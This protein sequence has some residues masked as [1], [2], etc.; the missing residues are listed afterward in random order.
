MPLAEYRSPVAK[1]LMRSAAYDILRDAII[2]GELEPG[3]AIKD[4]ELA[5]RM[6]L[7][8]TPV[9]EAVAKLADAGLI[10]LKPGVYTRVAPLDRRSVRATLDILRVLDD[11][12]VRTAVPAL[13][14]GDL[15]AMREANDRFAEAVAR[16]DV[17]A[18]LD[19]DNAFHGVLTRASG[20]P[21]LAR[22]IDQLHPTIHRILFRKFS[23][24]L[25]GRDTT[26][27]H[28]ELIELCARGDADAAAAR[29]ADHWQRLG[30]L[31]D[32][33]FDTHDPGATPG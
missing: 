33:L 1:Q 31:I 15:A 24:L 10:E 25:G 19:A 27:H 30:G 11:L 22:L 13:T 18:A 16:L 6:G 7:S 2:R 9:R 28:R 20:N 26:D 32:K 14:V 4:T 3:E 17:P 8:R 23:T 21:V 5:S 12:A 29:S